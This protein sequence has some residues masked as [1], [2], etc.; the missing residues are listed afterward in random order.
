MPRTAVAT[1]RL[2]AQR[3]NAG[4]RVLVC[5]GRN[6]TDR[7]AL[8]AA[9][10]RLHGSRRFTVVIAGGARGADVLAVQWAK[11]RDI[12]TEIYTADWRR[13]GRGAGP[14]RN[15]QMLDEGRPDLVVAFPG[16]KGTAGMTALALTAGIKVVHP[17][18]RRWPKKWP[19][20]RTGRTRQKK[21][22]AVRTRA[23]LNGSSRR[24]ISSPQ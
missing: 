15:K 8:Y 6:F 7:A 23:C 16:G 21:R 2:R 3:Q 4:C 13:F 22:N 20:S 24:K 11:D 5:G 18:R 19:A 17:G 14:R 9:L 1:P 10:D 12:A